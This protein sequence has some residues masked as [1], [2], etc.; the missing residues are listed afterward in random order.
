MVIVNNKILIG[1]IAITNLSNPEGKDTIPWV[2]ISWNYLP[3]TG[4]KEQG[5][6]TL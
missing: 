2:R 5:I 3:K 6:N 4:K 1:L